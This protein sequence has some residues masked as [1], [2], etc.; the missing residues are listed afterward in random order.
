[1]NQFRAAGELWLISETI[2]K[3]WQLERGWSDDLQ[4]LAAV[5]GR[6]TILKQLRACETDIQQLADAVLDGYYYGETFF[7][8]GSTF[9]ISQKNF[10]SLMKQLLT[11]A[12][13]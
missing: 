12:L 4:Q 13:L 6:L 9:S 10:E 8:G 3:S 5:D 1:M 7:Y 2:S 11:T